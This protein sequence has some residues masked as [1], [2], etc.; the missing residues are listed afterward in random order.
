MQ[1]RRIIKSIKQINSNDFMKRISLLFPSKIAGF[2]VLIFF[3]ALST[4]TFA[5]AGAMSKNVITSNGKKYYLH[6]VAH[7][8]SLFGIA[9]IYGVDVNVILAENPAAKKGIITGQ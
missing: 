7:A 3:L 9:K 4:G 5:Q 1:V 6:K 2:L 8:Q